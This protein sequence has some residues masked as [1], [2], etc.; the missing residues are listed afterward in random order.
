MVMK[1]AFL[2]SILGM[3]LLSDAAIAEEIKE[4]S[5]VAA[6]A[7]VAQEEKPGVIHQINTNTE[8]Y[9]GEDDVRAEDYEG[10]DLPPYESYDPNT[11][12]TDETQSDAEG[13]LN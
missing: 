9:R 11:G 8:D 5:P 1:F 6:A 2:A 3:F 13:N 12:L 4:K 10:Q 7:A